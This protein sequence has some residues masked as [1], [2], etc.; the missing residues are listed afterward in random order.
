MSRLGVI[1]IVLLA[2]LGRCMRT[3]F[4]QAGGFVRN[5][6]PLWAGKESVIQIKGLCVCHIEGDLG[7]G[8]ITRP[9]SNPSPTRPPLPPPPSLFNKRAAQCEEGLDGDRD[10]TFAWAVHH[11]D[12]LPYLGAPDAVCGWLY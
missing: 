5:A 9:M 7:T 12:D 10:T 1:L 4:E 8:V 11:M 3:P 6:E 2:H